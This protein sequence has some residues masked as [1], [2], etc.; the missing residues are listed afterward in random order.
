MSAEFYTQ[1]NGIAIIIAF[2]MLCLMIVLPFAGRLL[3]SIFFIA[4]ACYTWNTVQ[5][6][7]DLYNNYK[8]FAFF[9][10]YRDGIVQP[11]IDH[12][13]FSAKM[14]AILQLLTAIG[15]LLKNQVFKIAC[16]L[17]LL[18]LVAI[19]PLGIASFFPATLLPALGCFILLRKK[20][21]HYAWQLPVK[22]QPKPAGEPR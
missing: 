11:F 14:F 15:L 7:P 18:I 22:T 3:L 5:G 21:D 9:D 13:P 16:A 6:H 17:A 19:A 1:F 2:F 8:Q 12:L 20:T 4:T 10:W